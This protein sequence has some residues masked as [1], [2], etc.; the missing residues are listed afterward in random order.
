MITD[1][2]KRAT[3]YHEIGHALVAWLTAKSDPVHKVTIVPRGRALG[4]T[5]F[6]PEEDRISYNESQIRAKLDTLLGGRAA[7]R[8]IYGDLSTGAANDLKQA[9]RLAK[10]MV[11]QWGMSE[12]VG[13]ISLRSSEE[14]PFLGR[15]MSEPRDHSEHTAQLIDEE[16]A[17]ILREADERAYNLLRDNR[18]DMERLTEML[19]EREVITDGEIEQLLGKRVGF[20]SDAPEMSNGTVHPPGD[21]VVASLDN[22]S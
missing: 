12:R 11:T 17:R 15:E 8:L 4:V 10:M 21:S 20:E 18:Q 2:D 16:V 9:T 1:R 6:M 7:E 5:Q 22:P 19:I 14:H 3:A 13:P